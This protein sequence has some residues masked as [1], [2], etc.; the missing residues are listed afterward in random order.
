MSQVK[1]KYKTNFFS[2]ERTL[3]FDE[4]TISLY[5]KK[6]L[7]T[8]IKKEE[9]SNVRFGINWIQGRYFTI[10]RLYS[11]D[12]G[13]NTNQIM[14][15]RLRSIYGI[16]KIILGKKYDEIL[17]TLYEFY[18]FDKISD[19]VNNINKG[20]DIEIAGIV[21]SGEGITLD[22]KKSNG[23]IT[24][25]DLGSRAYTY[26]YTLFSNSKPEYYK[27]FTYLTDWN[28]V[29]VYSISRQILMEKG[30]YKE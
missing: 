12:L 3:V 11:L 17:N 23:L 7:L 24:W 25:D 29:L 14:K 22:P 20:T 4:N 9:L 1:I 21:F 18:L 15:I 2:T 19:Y 8:Q 28:A 13:S 6:R 10:G 30:F 26:Y 27:A 5:S 16:N